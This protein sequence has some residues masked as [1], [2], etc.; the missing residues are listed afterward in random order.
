MG[1]LHCGQMSTRSPTATS[2]LVVIISL[3]FW[4]LLTTFTSVD[5][6]KASTTPTRVLREVKNR[7]LVEDEIEEA[8][9]PVPEAYTSTPTPNVADGVT[10]GV[11][12]IEDA[13]PTRL[14]RPFHQKNPTPHTTT[15]FDQADP[16]SDPSD[17]GRTRIRFGSLTGSGAA[18]PSS[19]FQTPWRGAADRG[20]D[21]EIKGENC[22]GGLPCSATAII[23][24]CAGVA[25]RSELCCT[26]LEA[27]PGCPCDETVWCEISAA[28]GGGLRETWTE[29]CGLGD[30]SGKGPRGRC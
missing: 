24:A 5:A 20:P 6:W 12:T 16:A 2:A 13:S 4:A 21:A 8:P 26:A 18:T 10:P 7:R 22:A 23:A 25:R 27:N 29:Q 15:V 30:E 1:P 14:P 9:P 3:L 11:E 28:T 19:R 17:G